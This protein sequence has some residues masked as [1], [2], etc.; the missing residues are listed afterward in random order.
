MPLNVND[1]QMMGYT[2]LWQLLNTTIGT[3]VQL[4]RACAFAPWGDGVYV[5][6]EEDGKGL[7]GGWGCNTARLPLCSLYHRANEEN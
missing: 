5:F 2:R 7:G 4:S 3:E 6:G 1:S